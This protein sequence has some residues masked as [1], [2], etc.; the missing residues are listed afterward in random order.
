MKPLRHAVDIVTSEP[1]DRD[2][3]RARLLAARRRPVGG[4]NRR[5]ILTGYWD[6]GKIVGDFRSGRGTF[7]EPGRET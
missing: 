3:R 7:V 5:A 2:T 6:R 4:I 1:I